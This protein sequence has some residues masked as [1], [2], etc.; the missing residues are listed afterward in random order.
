MDDL[1]CPSCLVEVDEPGL[2]PYC[3]AL[4]DADDQL[5]KGG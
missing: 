1:R 4:A 2:C 3:K 5:C